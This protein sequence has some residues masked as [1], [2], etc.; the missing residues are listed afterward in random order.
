MPRM[1]RD[2]G[3]V[4]GRG[5]VSSPRKSRGSDPEDSLGVAPEFAAN[6]G[7]PAQVWDNRRLGNPGAHRESIM[8]TPDKEYAA[9]GGGVIAPPQMPWWK[10]PT[11]DQWYAFVAAWLGWT[12]DAFDFT[13]FLLIMHPIA[14]AF[15][16]SIPV[17]DVRVHDHLVDASCGGH[18]LGLAVRPD[19]TQDAA[20]DRDP[21]LFAVQFR[22]RPVA[23]LHVP[24][25]RPR[26]PRLLHGRGMAGRL[27]PGDGNLAA[28]LAR[29]DR[30][31]PAGILGHRLPDVLRHLR[32]VLQF[33]RLAR[34]ADGRRAAGA[35][36]RLCALLRQGAGSS[37]WK[38][39]GCRK[40]RSARSRCRCS[41]SS[42][43]A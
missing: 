22:R 32:P 25:R 14:Q 8:S 24:V 12:L 38:T 2:S 27:R 18:R 40:P 30:R 13:V 35:G 6:A 10:E 17:G 1:G 19:R 41:A 33:D 28:A 15:H 42:S 3:C 11:K 34:H 7:N 26:H 21:R 43:A 4:R 23:D 31:H 5:M 16:V 29:A 37:G 9:P 36:G 39:G 20:D